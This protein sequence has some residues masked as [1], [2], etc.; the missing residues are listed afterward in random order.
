M[1]PLCDQRAGGE[2]ELLA[3]HPVAAFRALCPGSLT[4]SERDGRA[5]TV[6]VC[7]VMHLV[8]PVCLSSWT[9]DGLLDLA[10]ILVVGHR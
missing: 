10:S 4:Q 6:F 1:A 8:P 5:S 2:N 9:M 7:F 3:F